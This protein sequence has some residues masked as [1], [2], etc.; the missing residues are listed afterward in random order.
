MKKEEN[1]I[2]L[3]PGD[4]LYRYDLSGKMPDN[5]N[6][7]VHS[8]EYNTSEYGPKNSIGAIFLYDVEIAAKQVL[9]AA[10]KKQEE[11]ENHIEQATITTTEILQEIKL[12]D[13][14]TDIDKCTQILS[15]LYE[16]GIDVITHDFFNY[17][18]KGKFWCHKKSFS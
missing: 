7:T 18:K 9:S 2:I 11:L 6:S 15:V 12:L 5:W 3:E 10:I 1:I 8:I 14:E 4:R 16:L 13:L 17:S